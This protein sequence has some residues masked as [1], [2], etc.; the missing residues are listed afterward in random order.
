MAAV[1]SRLQRLQVR[2]WPCTFK[3]AQKAAGKRTGSKYSAHS[4]IGAGAL[5]SRALRTTKPFSARVSTSC[6]AA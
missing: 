4:L 6:F 2:M 1:A 5:S 3:M